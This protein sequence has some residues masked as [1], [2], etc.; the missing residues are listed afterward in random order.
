MKTSSHP[1]ADA[2][3]LS[4]ATSNALPSSNVSNARRV[5]FVTPQPTMYHELLSHTHPPIGEVSLSTNHA[6]MQSLMTL[7]ATLSEEISNQ[8]HIRSQNRHCWAISPPMLLSE[9]GVQTC[10]RCDPVSPR[11]SIYA[12]PVRPHLLKVYSISN[13]YNKWR[14]HSAQNSRNP[15]NESLL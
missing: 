7:V 2:R 15:S 10:C 9:S 8:T 4:K 5:L 12:L 14:E 1:D 6:P 3:D 11:P 13:I